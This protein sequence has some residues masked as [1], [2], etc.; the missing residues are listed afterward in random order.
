MRLDAGTSA[1]SGNA[2]DATPMTRLAR[3]GIGLFC[4]C[5][6]LIWLPW[7]LGVIGGVSVQWWLDVGQW[8]ITRILRLPEHF[9]SSPSARDVLTPYVSSAVFLLMSGLLA[10]IWLVLDRCGLTHRLAFSWAFL[11]A[12][13][14]L[15]SFMMGY[16]WV[17]VLPAQFG[18]MASGAGT[19]YLIQQVGQL[20]P[21]DMLWAFMEASRSYQVAAGLVELLGGLL[22][23]T[24]K[25]TMWGAFISAAAMSN[26]VMLDIGYDATVKFLA[27]LILSL[28]A[29]MIAPYTKGL[30]TMLVRHAAGRSPEAVAVARRHRLQAVVLIAG[31]FTACLLVWWTYRD[32]E[33]TAQEFARSPAQTPLHGIWDV[34][35]VSR[36]GEDVPLLITDQSL[37]RR[38]VL[39]WGGTDGGAILVWMSDAVTYCNS[40][41][42]AKTQTLTIEPDSDSAA[43]KVGSAR[44][45]LPVPA[46]LFFHYTVGAR[47]ELVLTSADRD[48]PSV[49]IRL[50]RFDHSQYPLI[51][52]KRG[53]RW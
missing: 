15:A 34:E 32:A 21:R 44:P 30:G 5:T 47:D 28:A 11:V 1:D 20:G 22:L 13:L 16:G 48:G 24:R 6:F 45:T 43:T 29:A 18:L 10:A 50:R 27:G 41:I 8:T 26:V 23:L 2:S 38:L 37:W 51:A 14:M 35:E 42:D 4:G 49:S 40:K 19:D 25:T 17:K 31:V 36:A 52:H 9:V 33:K 46:R 12:R 7:W 53:W 39:P 3:F